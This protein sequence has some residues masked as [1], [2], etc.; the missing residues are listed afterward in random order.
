MK[1]R[2]T[3]NNYIVS[4]KTRSGKRHQKHFPKTPAGKREAK[5]FIKSVEAETAVEGNYL[6][7]GETLRFDEAVA[8]FLKAEE[9]RARRGEL[10]AAHVD[11]KRTA[12]DTFAAFEY[13]GRPLAGVRIGELTAGRVKKYLVDQLFGD[14]AHATAMKKWTVFKQ[15]LQHFVEIDDLRSNPARITLPT[16]PQEVPMERISKTAVL[17]IINHAK[18][19]Y[20]LAIKFSALTGVRAG[21]LMALT[22]ADIDFERALVRINKAVKKGGGVGAPKNVRAVRSIPIEASLLADLRQWKLAQPHTQR[23]RD[24]VF[25]TR[26]GNH[27]SPDNLRKRGLHPACAAAGVAQIRWHD[28]RHFYASILL[29]GVKASEAE[30]T[31]LLGHHSLAFTL[32]QYGHWLPET[33]RDDEIGDRLSAALI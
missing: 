9:A 2:E 27:N 10:G 28:L 22:W 7:P 21:E 3:E 13:D 11:N 17:S 26:A 8:D 1:I 30:I 4:T 15:M 16:S 6:N 24:L 14:C 31:S 29:F 5:A 20:R 19:M 25:P 12:L 33:R 23:V 32:K 18:P